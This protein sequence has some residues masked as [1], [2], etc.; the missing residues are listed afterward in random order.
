MTSLEVIVTGILALSIY[1]ILF[2]F[3]ID[4]IARVGYDISPYLILSFFSVVFTVI[5]V[6]LKVLLVVG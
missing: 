2:A 6:S 3:V 4:W 5:L 1:S